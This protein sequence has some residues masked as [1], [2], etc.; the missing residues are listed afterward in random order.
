MIVTRSL[1][2]LLFSSYS[3]NSFGFLLHS[4]YPFYRFS[5]VCRFYFTTQASLEPS[6]SLIPSLLPNHIQSISLKNW[7][8]FDD[9]SLE[10]SP[11]LGYIALSGETGSGKSIFLSA[12]QYCTG[13]TSFVK[14]RANG[15]KEDRSCSV[16]LDLR[17]EGNKDG[18]SVRSFRRSYL[19]S[20]KKSTCEID[21]QK[22]LMRDLQQTAGKSFRFWST[23]AIEKLDNEGFMNYIDRFVGPSLTTLLDDV[24]TSYSTWKKDRE[25]LMYLRKMEHKAED[26]EEVGLM[27]DYNE[28]LSKFYSKFDG[29]EKSIILWLQ[30]M[31]IDHSGDSDKSSNVELALIQSLISPQHSSEEAAWRWEDFISC[32]DYFR[33]YAKQMSELNPSKA[34]INVN[35]LDGAKKASNTVINSAIPPAD[36]KTTERFLYTKLREVEQLQSIM[37][38]LGVLSDR[39]SDHLSELQSMLHEAVASFQ[40]IAKSVTDLK[41]FFPDVSIILQKLAAMRSEWET[42][43]RK[44]G[45][46]PSGLRDKY[47]TIQAELRAIQDVWSLLPNQIKREQAAFDEYA[48][49]AGDLSQQRS[50]SAELLQERVNNLLPSLDMG[51]KRLKIEVISYDLESSTDGRGLCGELGWDRVQV[52]LILSPHS[53]ISSIDEQQGSR[54]TIST[55]TSHEDSLRSILSSGEAARL[56]LALETLSDQTHDTSMQQSQLP[57]LILDEI[58]AHIGG[59]AAVAVAKLLKKQ[60]KRRQVLV[61]THN[62]VIA[63]AADCHLIVRRVRNSYNA[64]SNEMQQSSEIKMLTSNEE[65]EMELSRMATGRLNIT[66]GMDLAKALLST[67]FTS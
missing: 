21:G 6:V 50:Q 42:L 36:F 64:V 2:I 39:A 44:H 30:S 60:G 8:V 41:S 38:E 25:H 11:S 22:A 34:N 13:E 59:D 23:D 37:A 32:E 45:T 63:A 49:A 46:T 1:H 29:L 58:D 14:V 61:V 3:L 47:L 55:T 62:P 28:E 15:A 35:T 24:S 65:R 33:K 12:L 10:L 67:N 26:E 31:H 7:G 54:T 16:S 66:A 48:L 18:S 52:S 19:G 9:A 17:S 5:G 56:A 20:Y 53:S 4:P 43:A 51:D 27:N 57:I 40:V